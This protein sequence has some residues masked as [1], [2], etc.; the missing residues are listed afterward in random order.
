MTDPKVL[1]VQASVA[2]RVCCRGWWGR[3]DERCSKCGGR[4]VETGRVF[5]IP[6]ARK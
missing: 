4:V 2:C 5:V 1:L 3:P 6:L